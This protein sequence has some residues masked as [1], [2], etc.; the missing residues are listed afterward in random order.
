MRHGWAF[1]FPFLD[2]VD[3]FQ[4]FVFI[5]GDLFRQI[6]VAHDL[7]V[8]SADV[9]GQRIVDVVHDHISFGTVKDS[10]TVRFSVHACRQDCEAAVRISQGDAFL[11]VHAG[12]CHE[13][14]GRNVL[15]IISK[16]HQC[17][18]QRIDSHV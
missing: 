12:L 13:H 18:I 10:V 6:D 1:F 8:G 14:G 9:D 2:A 3:H 15:E 11:T 5:T 17:E 4:N 16:M 7:M